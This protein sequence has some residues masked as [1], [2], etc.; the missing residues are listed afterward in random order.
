[1]TTAPA[2]ANP[3][4]IHKLVKL[5]AVAREVPRA[6]TVRQVPDVRRIKH[7]APRER[8]TFEAP[9]KLADGEVEMPWIWSVLRERVVSKLPSYEQDK[10]FTVV[11]SPVVVT[12][13]SD[14]VPGVGIAG[15]F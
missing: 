10:R 8:L 12:M 13:P 11:L 9:K 3:R 2:L 4:H 1:M 6:R 5:D 7:V 15:E 14:T